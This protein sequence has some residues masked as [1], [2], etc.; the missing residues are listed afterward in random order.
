MAGVRQ[1]DPTDD[2]S[3]SLK[4]QGA[5]R[6]YRLLSESRVTDIL[7]ERLDLFPVSQTPKLARHLL[8]LCLQYQF[9]PAFILS[10][11]EVESRFKVKAIS[12]VGAIGL[13]QVMPSTARMVTREWGLP[14]YSIRALM[15][16]FMNISIGM[17]YL[18][19]LRDRYRNLSPYYLVAAYNAGPA[20]V[21]T[22]IGRTGFN[23]IQTRSYFHAIRR[24]VHGMTE[25]NTSMFRNR[26]GV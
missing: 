5:S 19:W 15:D 4:H 8:S 23:P 11:I 13:M 22:F 6:S 3:F 16:P 21:D 26:Y 10:L 24:R 17:A 7:K 12:P 20:K 2:F 18:A 14:S 25:S 9:D 1:T